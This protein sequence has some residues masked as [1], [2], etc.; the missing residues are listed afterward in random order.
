MNTRRD[1]IAL[2]FRKGVI[3]H[4]SYAKIE[5]E[6]LFSSKATI[7]KVLSFSPWRNMSVFKTPSI[8]KIMLK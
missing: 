5:S 6:I 8:C 3:V 2:E 7:N 4:H 1:E